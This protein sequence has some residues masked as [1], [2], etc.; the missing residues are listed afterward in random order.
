MTYKTSCSKCSDEYI[1]LYKKDIENEL[2]HI[3]FD[4]DAIA[5]KNLKCQNHS[6]YIEYLYNCIIDICIKSSDRWLPAVGG[7]NKKKVIPGWNESVQI[8]L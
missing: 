3:K 4:H 5:C 6:D 7:C 8:L 1:Q 2:L